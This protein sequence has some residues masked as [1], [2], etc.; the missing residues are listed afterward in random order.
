MVSKNK[1][2]DDFA[3]HIDKRK[4]TVLFGFVFAGFF[5]KSCRQCFRSM[6]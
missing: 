1:K 5:K 3:L 6:F 2:I 4:S